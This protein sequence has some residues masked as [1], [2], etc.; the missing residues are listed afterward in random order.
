MPA[1]AVDGEALKDGTV[2][3]TGEAFHHAARVVR[4]EVGDEL[5]VLVDGR[6]LRRGRIVEV[7]KDRMTAR[8]GDAEP[9]RSEPAA[10]VTLYQS[11]LKG[12]KFELVVQ[13]AVELGAASIVPVATE[14]SIVKADGRSSR[15]ARWR[16]IAVSAACQSGRARV[17]E[18]HEPVPFDEAI[19]AASAA[20][21]AVLLYEGERC[22]AF[23]AVLAGP[24][25][26]RSLALLLGPEGGFSAGEVELARRCG[27]AV[28]GLGPRILRAETAAIAALSI[29]LYA[30]GEMDWR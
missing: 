2:T 4:L 3:L 20:E 25:P 19:R 1:F 12:E 11:L 13:K 6:E 23:G 8:V 30:L 26:P 29:A 16:K 7:H 10:A 14:R 9:L 28:A 5:A 18:I 21:K 24:A 17:P 27:I 22:A 15:S